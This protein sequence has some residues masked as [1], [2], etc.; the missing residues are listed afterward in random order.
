MGLADAHSCGLCLWGVAVPDGGRC[1]RRL[2][3]WMALQRFFTHLLIQMI[4][5]GGVET[6]V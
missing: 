6:N 2:L 4:Y 3:A 5:L 1:V